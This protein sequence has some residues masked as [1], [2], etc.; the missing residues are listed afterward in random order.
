MERKEGKPRS[1]HLLALLLCLS[2]SACFEPIQ[3]THPDQVLT[4]RRAL[5]KQFTRTLEPIGLVAS[6]RKEYK[7][8]EFL[9]LVQDLNTL[10]SKPWVYFPPD[11]NYPHTHARH[12]VW[13]Q[14][15][16]FKAA[17]EKYQASVQQLLL[18]AQAGRLEP[19]QRAMDGVTSSCKACHK[20]F[21]YE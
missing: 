8:D 21:R 20:D 13:S 12:A 10:A 2:L 5:F 19:V 7:P 6:G 4:K 3:D 15:E 18:A 14:P 17:Q 16:A 9:M 1:G 11:G